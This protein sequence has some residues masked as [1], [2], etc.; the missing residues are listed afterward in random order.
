M[1]SSSLPT[2]VRVALLF[3]VFSLQPGLPCRADAPA[4]EVSYALSEKLGPLR[5]AT[6]AKNY[7]AAL[8]LIASL[9]PDTKPDTYDRFVLQQLQAQMLLSQS[10]WAAAIPPLENILALD[11]THTARAPREAAWLTPATRL[12]VLRTLAQL[13]Y[14]LA[15]GLPATATPADRR[16]GYRRAL[17]YLRQ[18]APPPPTPPTPEYQSFLASLLYA[19]ATA[20][21]AAPDKAILSET[22]AAA[23]RGLALTAVPGE[24]FFVILLA[25][26]QQLGHP[27]AVA[28]TLERLV[29]VAPANKGYWSQLAGAWL[30]VAAVAA[31]GEPDR[32]SA[33]RSASFR[34]IHA[35][36]RAQ[37]HGALD[38][39][40]D[41]QN[42]VGLYLNLGSPEHAIA[43]L[44]AG[45]RDG[46]IEETRRNYE[47]L[48]AAWLG[49]ERPDRALE[50]YA[51]ATARFPKEGQLDLQAS[52]LLYS[53]G[54]PDQALATARAGLAK[55]SV[56]KPGLA[57]TWVAF[58]AWEL[59]RYDEAARAVDLAATF[60][61]SRPEELARLKAAL[62]EKTEGLKN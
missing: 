20:D 12:D 43:L 3:S 25:A 55:G 50:T 36:E 22:L 34:A 24:Q 61:D 32:P 56:E 59:A 44:E 8:A 11:A 29:A 15:S 14:T 4:P 31:A 17:D 35:I 9:L 60:P 58:L 5:E 62:T 39:P 19:L 10:A 7:P 21:P 42:L 1:T 37:K 54:H 23:G 2:L 46:R 48:A 49:I 16:A 52:Q 38:T 18:T 51:A 27:A 13:H 26:H 53:A 40:K 30:N 45:L 33:A 28:E 57:H 47:L 41:N 6:E